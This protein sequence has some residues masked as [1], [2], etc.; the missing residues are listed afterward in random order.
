MFF[1]LAGD[2]RP[3]YA[4]Q[5]DHFLSL[6]STD[7]AQSDGNTSADEFDFDEWNQERRYSSLLGI[8]FLFQLGG[9]S[10][11]LLSITPWGSY[12]VGGLHTGYTVLLGELAW[13]GG[14]QPGWIDSRL[15]RFLV[16]SPA[17]LTT[18]S[19]AGYNLFFANQ[20][21]PRTRFLVNSGTVFGVSTLY[22]AW[23]M[24]N[25]SREQSGM[26]HGS[27]SNKNSWEWIV[28]PT[29][30]GLSVEF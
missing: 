10:H 19:L 24:V 5:G 16:L 26:S 4:D 27:R 21:E 6:E 20:H 9:V 18:A 28:G 1:L 23:G 13:S 25:L 15:H 8:F 12:V 14:N 22:L 30:V 2:V 17:M 29:Y 7:V 11:G 3:A